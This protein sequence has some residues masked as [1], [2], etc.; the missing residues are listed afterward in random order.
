MNRLGKL[1]TALSFL[2]SLFPFISVVIIFFVC[3]SHFLWQA[4]FGQSERRNKA[5]ARG[6]AGTEERAG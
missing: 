6:G 4:F 3:S 2:R 5:A 1:E